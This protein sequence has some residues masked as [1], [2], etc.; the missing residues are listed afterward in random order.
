MRRYLQCKWMNA[1]HLC[2]DCCAKFATGLNIIISHSSKS[3]WVIKLS[4]CQNDSPIGDH[5]GQKDSRT[6]ANFAQHNC[7]A[8]IHLHCKYLRIGYSIFIHSFLSSARPWRARPYW[9]LHCSVI[10]ENVNNKTTM[11]KMKLTQWRIW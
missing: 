1:L 10:F 3:I 11:T 9:H 5:F 2:R 4:F 6:V 8:F 7:N